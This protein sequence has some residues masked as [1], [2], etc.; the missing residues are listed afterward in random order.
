MLQT[1][2]MI[3]EEG[4]KV[5]GFKANFGETE[6]QA[7]LPLLSWNTNLEEIMMAC[8]EGRLMESR[9]KR[10]IN[11]A[12]DD[13][14]AA[15]VVLAAPGFPRDIRTKLPIYINRLSQSTSKYIINF[16]LQLAKSKVNMVADLDEGD[17]PGEHYNFYLDAVS[18]SEPSQK[19]PTMESTGGRIMAVSAQAKTIEGAL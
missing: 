8:V 6:A 2:I 4:P 12:V 11:M 15:V 14:K 18:T 3:T 10:K 19:E 16:L 13:R 17:L 9:K 1:N 5:L 7:L